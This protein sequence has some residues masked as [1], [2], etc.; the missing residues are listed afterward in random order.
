MRCCLTALLCLLITAT[1][2]A[3]AGERHALLVGCSKYAALEQSWQLEGPANDVALVSHVLRTR[4]HFR[5]DHVKVLADESGIDRPTRDAIEREFRRLADRVREGDEVVILLAG[6][7]TQQPDD[8]PNDRSDYEPDGLDEVFCP[9]DIEAV[10]AQSD[11]QVVPNG[12]TD[13]QLGEW[14]KVIAARGANVW[15]LI[16]ACH[17]G[18]MTRGNG[19]EQT[20]QLPR[21]V[22]FS[23]DA[24]SR[25]PLEQF[26]AE[27]NRAAGTSSEVSPDHQSH[28]LILDRVVALYAAQPFEVTI[29]K[30]LPS[31]SLDAVPHGLL[32]YTVCQVL[33]QS[34]GAITYRE[35]VRRV[36]ATYVRMG[37]S[38]PTPLLEGRGIDRSVAGL[39]STSVA[40]FRPKL[41]RDGLNAW[42]IDAG[43]IHGMNSGDV[44][45]VRNENHPD[46]SVI[47]HVRVSRAGPLRSMVEPYRY[48]TQQTPGELKSGARCE[49]VF[50]DSGLRRLN[51]AIDDLTVDGTPLSSQDRSRILRGLSGIATTRKSLVS[52]TS[53]TESA[54]W[55]IRARGD[56]VVLIPS[57]GWAS[58]R[59]DQDPE[60]F[61]P[62][63]IGP[64]L[65]TWLLDR[66]RRIARA[67][68]L[69]ALASASTT[70]LGNASTM[71]PVQ[72]VR[73]K[74]EG[75]SQ[76]EPVQWDRR[77]ITLT[78]GDLVAFRVTNDRPFPID[79]TLLFVD[80]SFG[81]TAYFPERG[82]ADNRLTP[83]QALTSL[84]AEVTDETVGLE[85]M[86]AIAVRARPQRLPADFGYLAQPG[87]ERTRAIIDPVY[88]S[89]IGQLLN[90]AMDAEG[91]TRGLPQQRRQNS[92]HADHALG[93]VSWRVVP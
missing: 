85:H 79:L 7:G 90:Y 23:T 6:H 62:A 82:A 61:G 40:A 42:A 89:P 91:D 77:G 75:D 41:R 18:T 31:K 2:S 66:S 71:L 35:L 21:S 20:R 55:L 83:G 25:N 53:S 30:R 32:T 12:I 46:A 59:S 14:L 10:D 86:V 80:S 88:D 9:V 37:R 29:E 72:L 48:Q 16:D 64:Q 58:D 44:L 74:N 45:A 33:T 49:L 13:D 43:E 70:A 76:G 84:P 5:D 56:S 11:D 34:A 68:N 92:A 19:H 54:D 4:F 28:D 67:Q 1:D 81:I 63:A 52:T 15:I 57:S 24:G 27:R 3:V 60:M 65:S 22:L 78:R 26:P 51:F 87:V 93:V 69:L 36:H 47:G 39:E 50:R 17:S 8:D 38:F 73:L